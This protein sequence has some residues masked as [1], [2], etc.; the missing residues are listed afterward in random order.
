MQ[1]QSVSLLNRLPFPKEM[2][3]EIYSHSF[4]GMSYK[5]ASSTL[6]RVRSALS[7]SQ[8]ILRNVYFLLQKMMS[9]LS[10]ETD[11]ETITKGRAMCQNL[12]LSC[13]I[14]IQ[15]YEWSLVV[16]VLQQLQIYLHNLNFSAP[17]LDAIRQS[18]LNGIQSC[19]FTI[20]NPPT[21]ASP[22]EQMLRLLKTIGQ[23]LK[24]LHHEQFDMLGLRAKDILLEI[25]RRLVSI[26]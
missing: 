6:G 21:S 18:V 14:I 22:N 15:N 10:N 24:S 13:Q 9:S 8:N 3:A 25:I 2:D 20:E 23:N 4:D 16:T 11:T 7:N 26:P 17:H 12:L 19:Q 5:A 1:A